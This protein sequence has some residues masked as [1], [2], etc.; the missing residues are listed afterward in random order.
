MKNSKTFILSGILTL[1]AISCG[2]ATEEP[3]DEA[4]AL[5]ESGDFVAAKDKF[6]EIIPDDP[7]ARI[8]L[9]WSSLRLHENTYADSVLQLTDLSENDALA[10]YTLTAWATNK[11]QEAIDRAGTLLQRDAAYVFS[12]DDKMNS[13]D[14][15]WIQAASYWSLGNYIQ[16]LEC[17]KKL[18]PNF[19]SV[20]PSELLTKIESL[21][22]AK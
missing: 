18:D 19:N 13:D 3:L 20:S 14:L 4:W 17:V 5:F 22:G 16:A 6:I 21:G 12:H 1:M 15:I 2:P 8:G 9:G 10:A 11:N 7:T